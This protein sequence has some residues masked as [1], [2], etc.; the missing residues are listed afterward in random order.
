MLDR[1]RV[2]V[3]AVA[4]AVVLAVAPGCGHQGDEKAFCAQVGA[5]PALAP[6]LDAPDPAAAF[7]GAV[8]QLRALAKV[9]PSAIRN[10]VELVADAAAA[11]AASL[12]KGEPLSA[13]DDP[14]ALQ[15]QLDAAGAA[16]TRIV[17]YARDHCHVDLTPSSA[18]STTS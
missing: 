4:V 3:A 15:R 9:A 1:V 2:R 16:G 18:P 6:L 8:T 10:D 13:V 12:A 11:V 17:A 7:A 14:A 5:V